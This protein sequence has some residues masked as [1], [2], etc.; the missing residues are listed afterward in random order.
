M[1]LLE[2]QREFLYTPFFDSLHDLS[3]MPEKS[4]KIEGK[5]K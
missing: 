2:K 1:K 4:G 5:F 3:I